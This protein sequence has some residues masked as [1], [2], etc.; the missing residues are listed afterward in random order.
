[1]GIYNMILTNTTVTDNSGNTIVRT[2]GTVVNVGYFARDTEQSLSSSTNGTHWSV[3]Y[4]KLYG[5]YT[6]L[7]VM[8]KLAMA[9]CYNG[10]C[11]HYIE[12]GGVRN[13]SFN[14]D[15]DSWCN[16]DNAVHGTSEYTGLTAGGTTIKIGW[17]PNDGSSNLPSYWENPS[18]GRTDSRRRP[19]GSRIVVWEIV[20]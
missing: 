2:S 20:A 13:N 17:Q 12:V 7:V 18:G 3:S 4:T 19:N 14:Y 16:S 6:K 10:N 1:M 5:S 8:A 15:Y 11:G 9:Q